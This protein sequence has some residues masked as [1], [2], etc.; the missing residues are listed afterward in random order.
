MISDSEGC[1]DVVTAGNAPPNPSELLASPRMDEVLAQM[2]S[3]YDLLILDAPPSLLVS[4]AV[5]LLRKVEAV[6]VVCRLG[7]ATW[8]A[9]RR[10][11]QQLEA[12]HARVLGVV[13]NDARGRT[14]DDYS[15]GYGPEVQ[16]GLKAESRVSPNPTR[17]PGSVV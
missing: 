10:L 2:A 16:E 11:R 12:L 17:A 15:Y 8:G 3:E 14:A 5:P 9:A 1:L 7:S 6:L 4:D 13:V